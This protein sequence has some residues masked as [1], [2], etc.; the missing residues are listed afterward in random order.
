M[1]GVLIS[2]T[3]RYRL[4]KAYCFVSPDFYLLLVVSEFVTGD[5]S[6]HHTLGNYIYQKRIVT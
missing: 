5:I 6:W 1:Y 3:N 4:V 2:V